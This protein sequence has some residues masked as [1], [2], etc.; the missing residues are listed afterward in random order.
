MI[1]ALGGDKKLRILISNRQHVVHTML[2]YLRDLTPISV[3]SNILT[4]R[5]RFRLPFSLVIP[6]PC[7]LPCLYL[8]HLLVARFALLWHV[9]VPSTTQNQRPHLS[10][11]PQSAFISC[12][13]T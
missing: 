4:G 7:R 2:C 1:V 12:L 11:N 13:E 6:L 9:L 10:R 8:L 3:T 5:T